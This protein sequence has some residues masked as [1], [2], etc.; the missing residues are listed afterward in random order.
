MY[1]AIA[2][3]AILGA[4]FLYRSNKFKL[5][6]EKQ[7]SIVL[8]TQKEEAELL[9]KLKEEE[10]ARIEAENRL[11]SAQKEQ[12]QK[13]LLAG[14]LQIEHK[15]ELLQSLKEKFN[16]EK[17]TDKAQLKLNQILHSEMQIDQN[18]DQVRNDLQDINPEFFRKLNEKSVQKLT[19]LDLKY[20]AAIHSKLSTKQIAML[21]SVEPESVR[22][23]KYR[24]K[25]KLN[26]GKDD[27]L[28]V[29]LME[30]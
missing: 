15:N 17:F 14:T 20:C 8:E 18:L 25:Q 2:I 1:L 21:F 23:S 4:I 28:E 30:I 29:F 3:L 26:L 7:K 12:M 10:N 16:Q 22:M 11:F 9:A 19:A 6:F 5:K 13:Q 24:I 27:D